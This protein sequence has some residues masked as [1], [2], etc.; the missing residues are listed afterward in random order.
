MVRQVDFK[1]MNSKYTVDQ[2]VPFEGGG[3]PDDIASATHAAAVVTLPADAS[4]PNEISQIHCGFSATPGVGAT[5][6]ITDGGNT[7]WQVPIPTA[8]PFEFNFRPPRCN[9]APGSALVVTLSDGGASIVGYVNVN[10]RKR[11]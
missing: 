10:A 4:R 2:T 8:G 3:S 7:A 11:L 1:Q 5:L 6:T 9:A